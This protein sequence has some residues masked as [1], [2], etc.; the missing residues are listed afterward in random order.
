MI[1]W[2]RYL[3]CPSKEE[4]RHRRPADVRHSSKTASR[5]TADG[6]GVRRKQ[7]EHK[8]PLQEVPEGQIS[9]EP[10]RNITV[11]HLQLPAF[12]PDV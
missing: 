6:A 4:L 9:K 3:T 10:E 1:P 8:S 2:L 5:A 11:L 12:G 7:E